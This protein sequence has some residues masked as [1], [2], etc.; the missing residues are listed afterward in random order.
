MLRLVGTIVDGTRPRGIFAVGPAGSEMKAVGEKAGGAEVLRIDERS[1]TV[2]VDGRTVMLKLEKPNALGVGE[3]PP[4]DAGDQ[5]A[6]ARST[7]SAP[8]GS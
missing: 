7:G 5:P 6:S 2:S 3:P 1:A 4:T 8:D